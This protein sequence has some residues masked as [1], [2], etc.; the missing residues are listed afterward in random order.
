MKFVPTVVHNLPH[1]GYRFERWPSQPFAEACCYQYSCRQVG[2][3]NSGSRIKGI[4]S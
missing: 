4:E 3:P 2:W 1:L